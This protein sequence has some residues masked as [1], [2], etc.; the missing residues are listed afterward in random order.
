MLKQNDMIKVHFY[1]DG[2]RSH[3]EVKTRNYDKIFKVYEKDGRLGFDWNTEK[4]PYICKGDV[5]TPFETFAQNVF[6]ENVKTG[7]FYHFDNISNKVIEAEGN[8]E[9]TSVLR[10][11][12]NIQKSLESNEQQK[13]YATSHKERRNEPCQ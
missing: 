4:S 10:Q 12:K 3:Q 11:M 7:Q 2:N 6:F 13:S 1:L 8:S 9:K 5:F